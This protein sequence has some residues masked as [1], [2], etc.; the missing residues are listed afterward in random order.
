MTVNT[1]KC[2]TNLFCEAI[3]K[4]Q[5]FTAFP[6]QGAHNKIRA[7]KQLNQTTIT[8]D[9]EANEKPEKHVITLQTFER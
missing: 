5:C 9:R 4:Q 2:E 6:L 8:Q 3:W 1:L 7:E